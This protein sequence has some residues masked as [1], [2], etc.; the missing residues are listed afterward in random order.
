[1][2]LAER[3]AYKIFPVSPESIILNPPGPDKIRAILDSKDE[4]FYALNQG[5]RDLLIQEGR[6]Y[7]LKF[8]NNPLVMLLRPVRVT[9]TGFLISQNAAKSGFLI[10][11]TGSYQA[12]IKDGLYDPNRGDIWVWPLIKKNLPNKPAFISGTDMGPDRLTPRV[13]LR[14]EYSL[15]RLYRPAAFVDSGY[16]YLPHG[17]RTGETVY[18]GERIREVL[19]GW[20]EPLVRRP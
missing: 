12:P 14:R 15:N 9:R 5:L 7:D 3:I 18:E 17:L 4:I 19:K 16:A 20:V 8:P 6:T 11:E 10:V 1:M 2:A 13:V